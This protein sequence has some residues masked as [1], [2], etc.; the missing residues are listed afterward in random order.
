LSLREKIRAD[1][2]AVEPEKDI[3]FGAELNFTEWDGGLGTRTKKRTG[4]RPRCRRHRF[5]FPLP[6]P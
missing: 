5:P 4:V 1:I 3:Y 6:F 2:E